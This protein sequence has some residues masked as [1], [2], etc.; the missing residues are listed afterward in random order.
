MVR[1]VDTSE[2]KIDSGIKY[3]NSSLMY[4]NDDTQVL[5]NLAGAYSINKDY[6][7]ALNTIEK[8]LRINPNYP[9]A[10]NL[11]QQLLAALKSK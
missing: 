8:C 10:N 1:I 3:L 6:Q 11:K 2:N 7:N 4:K 5:F 9:K